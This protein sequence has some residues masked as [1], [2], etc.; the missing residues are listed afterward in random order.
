MTE[1]THALAQE[2]EQTT[3]EITYILTD[4]SEQTVPAQYGESV[5]RTALQN[6]VP[7]IIGECGGELSCGTCHV[8]VD[9]EWADRIDPQSEEERELLDMMNDVTAESR[10]SCQIHLKP[11]C[12]GFRSRIAEQQ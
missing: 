10:L 4:G 2:A 11:G 7:G 12:A 3:T 1:T 9:A 5:M 8:Y 6:D